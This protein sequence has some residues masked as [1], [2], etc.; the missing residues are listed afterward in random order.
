MQ[1]RVLQCH[2]E[3]KEM[4]EGLGAGEGLGQRSM[5]MQRG[6]CN[7]IETV[8]LLSIGSMTK[9]GPNAVGQSVLFW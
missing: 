9:L 7:A 4:G 1:R 5:A 8:C 2:E 3:E 6:V